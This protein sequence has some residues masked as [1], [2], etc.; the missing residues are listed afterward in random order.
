MDKNI[1]ISFDEENDVIYLSLRE[2]AAI[3]S[4]E[5]TEDVRIE[6]DAQ[7]NIVEIEIFN[8]TKML[9]SAVEKKVKET[10]K[11]IQK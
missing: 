9:A 2:G 7:G 6:Y 3:D 4:E 8:I 11:D 10:L 5:I 1:K